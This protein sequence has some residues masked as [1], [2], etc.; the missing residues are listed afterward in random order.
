LSRKSGRPEEQQKGKGRAGKMK[1]ST[2]K[3]TPRR[4][5]RLRT[6]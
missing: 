6:R 2:V 1:A 5:K 4:S 3:D